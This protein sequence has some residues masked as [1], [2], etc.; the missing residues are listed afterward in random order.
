MQFPEVRTRIVEARRVQIAENSRVAEGRE[1]KRLRDQRQLG[2]SLH[3]LKNSLSV[4]IKCN[5]IL[6]QRL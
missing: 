1:W 4:S 5:E 3:K 2:G 6:K